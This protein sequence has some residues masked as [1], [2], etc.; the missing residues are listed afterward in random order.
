MPDY[1]KLYVMMFNAATAALA[2]MER[3]DIGQAKEILKKA[4]CAAEELYVTAEE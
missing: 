1:Q 4:Q 3:L 2:A